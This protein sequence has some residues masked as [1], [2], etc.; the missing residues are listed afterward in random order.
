MRIILDDDYCSTKC[1]CDICESTKG[2]GIE[3][4][5]AEWNTISN[6]YFKLRMEMDI[7]KPLSFVQ[8]LR[9]LIELKRSK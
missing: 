6:S 3:I 5:D 1:S 9:K 2:L 8:Y 7:Y 4:T